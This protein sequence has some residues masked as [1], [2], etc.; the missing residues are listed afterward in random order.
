MSSD[1]LSDRVFRYSSDLERLRLLKSGRSV[2]A[3][4]AKK[5]HDLGNA[6]R[7]DAAKKLVGTCDNVVV[8][9]PGKGISGGLFDVRFDPANE[10]DELSLCA[11]MKFYLME[12]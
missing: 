10:L 8:Q 9:Y 6:M 4:R 3:E 1:G 11:L 7:F 12:R 5:M 2:M